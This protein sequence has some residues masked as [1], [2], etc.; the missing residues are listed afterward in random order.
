MR[1]TKIINYNPSEGCRVEW[2]EGPE[3]MSVDVMGLQ[4]MRIEDSNHGF[5]QHEIPLAHHESSLHKLFDY[6]LQHLL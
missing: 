4:V 5:Q 1:E 6:I 2:I 3:D